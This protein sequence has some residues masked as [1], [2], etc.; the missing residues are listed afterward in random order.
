MTVALRD[1]PDTLS[2]TLGLPLPCWHGLRVQGRAHPPPKEIHQIN[3]DV[4]LPGTRY[5]VAFVPAAAHVLRRRA[6]F[7]PPR[8]YAP[9]FSACAAR[10][11]RP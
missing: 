2:A 11:R 9:A 8:T 7:T 6:R 1:T 3:K 4:P 10:G 5:S